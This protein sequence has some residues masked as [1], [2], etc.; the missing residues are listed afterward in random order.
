MGRGVL[1]PC[2]EGSHWR[3]RTEEG[4]KYYQ[5]IPGIADEVHTKLGPIRSTAFFFFSLS[6]RIGP[7]GG[8]AVFPS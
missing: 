6:F 2:V 4:E 5:S 3:Q 8:A 7:V 1:C